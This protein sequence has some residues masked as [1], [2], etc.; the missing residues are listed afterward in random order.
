M[1]VALLH[2]DVHCA[3]G[4]GVIGRALLHDGAILAEGVALLHADAGNA[5]AHAGAGG[6]LAVLHEGV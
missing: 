4:A 5:D 6:G 2:A 3:A 1:G